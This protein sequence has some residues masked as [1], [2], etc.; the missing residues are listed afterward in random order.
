MS[1]GSSGKWGKAVTQARVIERM[2]DGWTLTQSR[3]APGKRSEHW[4]T[5]RPPA[6]VDADSDRVSTALVHRMRQQRLLRVFRRADM[7]EAVLVDP[8]VE[9]TYA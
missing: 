1:G 4:F 9:A 2:R 3:T 8:V 6:G 5:L 7:R